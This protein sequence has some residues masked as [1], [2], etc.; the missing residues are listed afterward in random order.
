MRTC[1]T[2][3]HVKKHILTNFT[4]HHVEQ[5]LITGTIQVLPRGYTTYN[6]CHVGEI[7]DVHM[8]HMYTYNNLI[9]FLHFT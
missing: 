6:V 3:F 1:T 7:N 2:Y 8:Y 9:F 5:V 4:R